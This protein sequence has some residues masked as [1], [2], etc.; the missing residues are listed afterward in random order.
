MALPRNGSTRRSTRRTGTESTNS[1]ENPE[2]SANMLAQLR[3]EN[4]LQKEARERRK[5]HQAHIQV[6][7]RCG[8]TKFDGGDN[9]EPWL[10]N[11]DHFMKLNRDV[12]E[13]ITEQEAVT[14]V[15]TLLTE[16]VQSLLDRD[17]T[18]ITV[19][20][21][22]NKLR[23][24]YQDKVDYKRK[25]HNIAQNTNESASDFLA[26]IRLILNKTDNVESPMTKA[27][28]DDRTLQIFW[29]KSTQ[30]IERSLTLKNPSTIEEALQHALVVEDQRSVE[31]PTKKQKTVKFDNNKLSDDTLTAIT[32]S[33][34]DEPYKN[35]FGNRFKQM[36]EKLNNVA[37]KNTESI[38]GVK[39]DLVTIKNEILTSLKDI[40]NQYKNP[41]KPYDRPH[42]YHNSRPYSRQPH[43]NQFQVNDT[44][45]RGNHLR[46][47]HLCGQSG[48]LF[49]Q[50]RRSSDQQ[51]RELADHL[52]SNREPSSS[53]TAKRDSKY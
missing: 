10:R 18:L 8:I 23:M 34:V 47:C 3:M 37:Q 52:N 27:Q 6:L 16:K 41:T 42:P 35:D 7:N 24:T 28:L 19:T 13:N 14:F 50:C 39:A 21:L 2:A 5:E 11:L 15:K 53:M 36:N 49:R 43:S 12:V 9:I 4:E 45:Y 32:Q 31:N 30:D 40:T 29:Y 38:T 1:E 17:Q 44:K 48:H 51:I 46:I 33:P 22:I 20:D 26:R 25:L